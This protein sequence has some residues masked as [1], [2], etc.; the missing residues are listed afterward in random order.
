MQ[1]ELSTT[2]QGLNLVKD[3]GDIRDMLESDSF[4]VVNLVKQGEAATHEYGVIIM[5]I[6]HILTVRPKT[7]INHVHREAN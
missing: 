3:L 4:K 7:S 2:L 6:R 5:Y 1:A